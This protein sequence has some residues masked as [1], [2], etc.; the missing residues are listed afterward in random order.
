MLY[1]ILAP[2][3]RMTTELKCIVFL[4]EIVSDMGE[5]FFKQVARGKENFIGNRRCQRK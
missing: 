3:H 2:K 1:H 4:R 5:A